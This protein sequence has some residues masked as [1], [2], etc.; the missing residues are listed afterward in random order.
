MTVWNNTRWIMSEEKIDQIVDFI[1]NYLANIG[2]PTFLIVII[3]WLLWVAATKPENFQIYFG[4][5]QKILAYPFK[6]IRKT[7]IKNNIEGPCTKALK[8]IASELP[9]LEIPSLNIEW[10]NKENL[11]TKLKEGKAIVRLKFEDDETKNII[12]ATSVYVK[13]A[14]LKHAKPYLAKSFR[15]AIDLSIT[16]KILLKSTKNSITLS[17]FIDENSNLEDVVSEKCE[18]IEEID[19]NGLFTR[20]LLRELDLFGK[21]LNGRHIKDEYKKEADEF[22]Q[23]V[24]EIATR[25][26]DDDTPLAFSKQIIKAGVVLVAKPETYT[27]YGIKPYLR[28]IKL[29][30][31]K[32]I[33]SFYLLARGGSVE[34]L[35]AVATELLNTGNFILINQPKE[36]KDIKNRSAICYCIRIDE[37]SIFTNTRKEIGEAIIA[38]LP[39]AA[40]VARVNPT[41]LKLD[42]NG[43][44]GYIKKDNISIINIDDATLYFRE[45]SYIEAI[46]IEIQEK[47]VIEFTLRNTKSDPNNYI[48]THFEIGKRIEGKIKEVEDNFARIDIGEEAIDG[49]AY[50][51]DLTY[52]RFSF[53]HQLFPIG[54]TFEFDV[55][56]YNF[57]K[58]S[59]RLAL[60]DLKDPWKNIFYSK[61]SPVN[62]TICKRTTKSF[63]GEIAEGVDAS[64]SFRELDWIEGDAKK[65][66]DSIKLNDNISCLVDNIDK[67]KRVVYLTLKEKDN[68]PYV[69]FEKENRGKDFNL[70]IDEVNSYGI[71]GHINS[72][73]RYN[74]Y[75]PSYET[76]W[77]KAKFHY[78]KKKGYQV[79]IIDLD[80]FQTKLIGSIK[81]FLP[82]PLSEFADTFRIGQTLSHLEIKEVF[83]WGIY[84]NIEHR[85][86]TYK[87][88]LHRNDICDGYIVCE[89]L[90]E[91]LNDIPLILDNI[92]FENNIISLSLRKL[93]DTNSERRNTLNYTRTYEGYIITANRDGTYN[94][95]FRNLWIIG[96]L[97]TSKKYPIG[98]KIEVRPSKINS[99]LILTDK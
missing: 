20:V 99:E 87:A 34:I 8:S 91:A 4:F 47:G 39:I 62:L 60:A 23:Y 12:K 32:G 11:E 51:K 85:N 1:Q 18:L 24:D 89:S 68:N 35:K 45:G 48:T 66:E 80:K 31:A 16:K 33:D 5:F 54:Q 70:I 94:V 63:V 81:P 26:F 17:Y 98:I 95:F 67:D 61:Y 90:N 97:E 64:L 84:Y 49:F 38:K 74:I 15:E 72:D 65:K 83:K 46:P 2:L 13:D 53:L 77:T 6:F 19:D 55:L 40:V 76:S 29:G 69:V 10:V 96:K 41:F 58:G 73:K 30:I 88:L 92:D 22:L 43:L 37:N 78:D 52:S 79:R 27:N 28:R 57:E 44:E 7:A 71:I 42:I 56:G 86:K 9:D 21:K 82:H 25:E 75:I 50:R 3:I 14:F 93:L 59:I 36:Y